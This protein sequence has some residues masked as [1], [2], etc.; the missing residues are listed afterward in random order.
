MYLVT[1]CSL[2]R[3]EHTH[4]HTHTHTHIDTN[5][6]THKHIHT[7]HIHIHAHTHTCIRMDLTVTTARARVHTHTHTHPHTH[8]HTNIPFP[9]P[10][11]THMHPHGPN[12]YDRPVHT[13]PGMISGR[14]K[15]HHLLVW[16]L[17]IYT[18]CSGTTLETPFYSSAAL[19][20]RILGSPQIALDG[21]Y[22]SAT[23]CFC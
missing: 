16:D 1:P 21:F 15:G 23:T 13:A 14:K 3:L 19:F 20:G 5:T 10:T 22:F 18:S 7:Q 8:T 17:E 9:L 6:Y 11:H 12:S 4:T 2:P